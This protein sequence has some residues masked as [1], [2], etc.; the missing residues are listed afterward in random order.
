MSA[1]DENWG[2]DDISISGPSQAAEAAVI[3]DERAIMIGSEQQEQAHAKAKT[4]TVGTPSGEA[5]TVELNQPRGATR[6]PGLFT[7]G[8]ESDDAA[9]KFPSRAGA[10]TLNPHRNVNP[11]FN[12][13]TSYDRESNKHPSA[14]S[15]VANRFELFLLGD[16]E[17]KVTETPDTRIPSTSIFAFNKEDHTLGNLLRSR[18]L[19]SSHVN[20]AGYRVP[21]PLVSKFEL[22]IQTD[23]TITPRAALVQCCR[24]LVNDL[25]ILGR[26]FT[27]EWELRKMVGEGGNGAGG[28]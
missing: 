5:S 24:D 11:S 10:S 23:G 14:E 20:F 8:K 6:N 28:E 3:G 17:K 12:A 19:Q 15:N 22:R 27:K 18:L 16:G 26:E 9:P 21:H 7:L 2:G 25:G 1:P 4:T 13:Q